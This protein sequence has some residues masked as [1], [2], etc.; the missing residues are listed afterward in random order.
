VGVM[1]DLGAFDGAKPGAELF[2]EHRVSWVPAT[3]GAQQLKGMG[4]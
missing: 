1:D 4:E 3:E 2:T